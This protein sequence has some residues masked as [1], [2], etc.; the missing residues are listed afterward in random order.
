MNCEVALVQEIVERRFSQ[1]Q[2]LLNDG[3]YAPKAGEI[4]YNAGKDRVQLTTML[5][6]STYGSTLRMARALW[7][8][9]H[10]EYWKN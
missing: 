8:L 9:W 4:V 10:W 2:E 7:P 1:Y 6:V 3:T 5:M